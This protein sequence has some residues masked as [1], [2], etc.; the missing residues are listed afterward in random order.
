MGHQRTPSCGHVLS[1]IEFRT[2]L[3][4]L[5]FFGPKQSVQCSFCLKLQHFSARAAIVW[6]NWVETR[7]VE[8]ELC[9][10]SGL[11]LVSESTNFKQLAKRVVFGFVVDTS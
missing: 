9:E 6:T 1:D 5:Y 7:A 10:Q 8:L 2:M 11:E 4:L 3:E